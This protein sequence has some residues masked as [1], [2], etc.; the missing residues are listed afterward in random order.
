MVRTP[1]GT[2]LTGERDSAEVVALSPDGDETRVQA[3]FEPLFANGESGL[4]GMTLALD[5]AESRE[6]FT[7]VAQGGDIDSVRVLKWDVAEDYSAL[8]APEPVVEGIP[9]AENGLHSG[10]SMTTHPE[11]GS[12]FIGTGDAFDGSVPQDLDSLGGKVLNITP[13]GEP[14]PHAIDDDTV[15]GDT[16]VSTYG[17]RNVQGLA[18][19]PGTNQLYTAE[20]GPAY[21]DE[22]NRHVV[23]G[24]YGWAPDV[25][26]DYDQEV[27]MT[28]LERFPDA[29][30]A[31]FSSGSSR[32]APA[33]AAFLD[34]DQ[35]GQFDGALAVATLR[36]QQILLFQLSEDGESVEDTAVI[37]IGDKG[38]MR[39][40]TPE[41]NGDLLVTTSNGGGDDEVF[42]LG[43]A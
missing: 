22:I 24:N 4:M 41:P 2:V 15:D 12:I 39:S 1:D 13:E 19:Q 26:S 25:L 29:V 30:E 21:D 37:V 3:N 11:D 16:I 35:W 40:L 9:M 10:C 38:R 33:G 27:P 8:T 20:H 17:H 32:L 31:V 34:G 28:D 42:V 6:I 7:C 43:P 18:F 14:G 36:A 23:G 5:F